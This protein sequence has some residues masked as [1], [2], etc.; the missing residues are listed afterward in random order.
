MGVKLKPIGEQTIVITGASSGIGRATALM[1]ADRGAK[2]VA[3]ARNETALREVVR[4]IDD[5]GGT[6]IYV[7][8]DVSKADELDNAAQ[9]TVAQYGGFDTWVND[10]GVGMYGRL[11]QIPLEDKRRL[12]DVTFWGVVNGCRS[13]LP[14]L[15]ERGGAI[16]NIGSVESDVAIPLTGIYAAAKHA[17]K[18]YTE[19]LRMELD[20]DDVP[21]SVSLI[22]PS[23]I[24]TP[25]FRHARN[26]LE[27]EPQPTPP[28]YAAEVV[29]EAIL[30]CAEHP[31][32]DVVVG[33]GGKM[34]S[35]IR[36]GSVRLTDRF[37]EATQFK[38]QKTDR[39]ADMYDDILFDAPT[40]KG[41]V[42]GDYSGHVMQS[43]A[44]T[45]AKLHPLLGTAVVAGVGLAIAAG[46]RR[47]GG[48]GD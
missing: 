13:A 45:S 35:E 31:T 20:H 30:H 44:Y 32:P 16:I 36:K 15:R 9:T 27:V 47:F 1:A 33:G 10:A 26:H 37:M 3:V 17:V 4:E 24:D 40:D 48:R 19:T 41:T 22:K 6:A 46:V 23:G 25:F 5:K 21:V 18:A 8:A 43:S 29:A 12:F 34:M 42:G 39:P 7:V 11:D 14:Q 38:G 2:V 28:V